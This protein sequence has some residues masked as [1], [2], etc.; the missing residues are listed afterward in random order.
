MQCRKAHRGKTGPAAASGSRVRAAAASRDGD[1]V[2]TGRTRLHGQGEVTRLGTGIFSM[3]KLVNLLVKKL[4]PNDF[5]E[6][7]ALLQDVLTHYTT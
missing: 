3:V 2:A 4:T 6:A 5:N 1:R 7:M